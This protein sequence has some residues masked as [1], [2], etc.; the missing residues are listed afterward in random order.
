MSEGEDG[1][2]EVIAEE[3]WEVPEQVLFPNASL[4]CGYFE[5]EIKENQQTRERHCMQGVC[6]PCAKEFVYKG[7]FH[8]RSLSPTPGEGGSLTPLTHVSPHDKAHRAALF[9]S[10]TTHL[11]TAGVSHPEACFSL[12]C[13]MF[14]SLAYVCVCGGGLL[15]SGYFHVLAQCT[16]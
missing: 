9:I 8:L 13:S 4:V 7:H 15:I 10:L 2:V 12:R 3:S 6:F 5:S 1:R 14:L 16:C 11:P